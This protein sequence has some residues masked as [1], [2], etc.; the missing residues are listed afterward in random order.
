LGNHRIALAVPRRASAGA[1]FRRD[2]SGDSTPRSFVFE[3]SF[4]PIWDESI[5]EGADSWN[6]IPKWWRM[7]RELQKHD[8]EYD[9]IV[10][11]GE[12]LSLAMLMRQWRSRSKKPHIAMMYQFEKPNIRVP[13][14]VCKKNLHAVVTWS[15]VQRN[16]LIERIRFPRERVY[17]VRHYVDQ[18]FYRPRAVIAEDMYCAVGAE[19]RDYAT[20]LDAARGAG[21]RC[22][23]ATDHV[24]I[25][26][27]LR[28]S[29]RRVAIESMHAQ[30]DPL[31]TAGRLSLDELRTLYARSKFVVVPLLPSDTDNGITCILE[32][33]AMG[34]P[35]IC[36]RTRGQVDAVQEGV[37]GLYVPIGDAAALRS[38]ISSLWNEPERAREMGRNARAYIEKH[39]SL[40]GF[41]SAVRSAVEAS[42]EGVPAPDTWWG[43]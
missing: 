7:A 26:G 12:K 2:P 24:R 35:V 29:D 10:S 23:I 14:T 19:M 15:S 27:W 11:W 37:T 8:D 1:N 6:A 39:H 18:L 20:F 13:L 25:P 33:M 42:L 38:A 40:E 17:L 16:A 36:S 21:Y 30:Q 22:H 5:L 31:I 4:A 3:E 34:K 32:A 28:L 41:T 9:A 43:Q